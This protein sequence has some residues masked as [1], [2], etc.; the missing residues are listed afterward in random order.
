MIQSTTPLET[1]S[2]DQRY[3]L[4]YLLPRQVQQRIEDTYLHW[5]GIT[6]PSMGYHIT[7]LGPFVIT[8]EHTQD[9]LEVFAGLCLSQEAFSITLGKPGIFQNATTQVAY[10]GL[11]NPRPMRMLH[12]VIL[13]GVRGIVAAPSPEY[14]LWT[15]EQYVPHVTLGIGL[16]EDAARDF[17]DFA[18][19]QPLKI[20]CQVQELCLFKQ[21]GNS[22]WQQIARY[23]LQANTHHTRL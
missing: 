3:G 20:R 19:S 17:L 12:G 23:P 16:D 7:V 18:H 13:E 1:G 2:S 8:E 4:G 22:A 10:L 15:V 9:D 21:L 11:N 14:H 6:R 5:Q